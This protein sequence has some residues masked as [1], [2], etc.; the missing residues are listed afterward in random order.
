MIGFATAEH[1]SLDFLGVGPQDD[2]VILAIAW[3]AISPF[4]AARSMWVF[5]DKAGSSH[6]PKT[7]SDVTSSTC[8]PLSAMVVWRSSVV[9]CFLVKWIS[10][11]L[12]DANCA[13]N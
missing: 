1:N 4:V 2:P 12:S 8:R 3:N 13:P 11:Y 10:W 6:T 5:K 7:L 9:L